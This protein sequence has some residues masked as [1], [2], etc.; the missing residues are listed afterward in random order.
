MQ[1][2]VELVRDTVGRHDTFNFACS[3]KYYDDMGY[4][5]HVNCTDNFNGA[6]DPFDVD[7]LN[8]LPGFDSA[9]RP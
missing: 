4:P 1:T 6:L 7:Y 5:G 8:V 3:A 9:G 2:L